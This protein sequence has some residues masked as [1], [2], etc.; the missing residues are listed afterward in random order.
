V[1]KTEGYW[2]TLKHKGKNV[3]NPEAAESGKVAN[4]RVEAPDSVTG[5]QTVKLIRVLRDKRECNC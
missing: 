1:K 2:K 3:F 4:S 5:G